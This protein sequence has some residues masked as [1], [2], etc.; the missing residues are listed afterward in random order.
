[1]F[2][3]S[4]FAFVILNFF[5]SSA[6]AV[7]LSDTERE[8]R[9][10]DF[11][12]ISERVLAQRS[13][14]DIIGNGAGLA[15]QNITYLFRHLDRYLILGLNQGEFLDSQQKEIVRK[16]LKLVLKNRFNDKA[17]IFLN[18]NIFEDFFHDVLDPEERIAKT[19]FSS[20]FPIFFNINQVYR[21]GLANEVSSLLG[22]LIHELG[23]QGGV[24]SHHYLDE[25]S[26]DLRM[27]FESFYS[28][29][30]VDYEGLEFSFS[31]YKEHGRSA[32]D[33]GVLSIGKKTFI[34]FSVNDSNYKCPNDGRLHSMN[35]QN[36]HFLNLEKKKDE[37]T[38]KISVWAEITCSTL[39]L[40]SVTSMRE[41]LSFEFRLKKMNENEEFNFHG[42]DVSREDFKRFEL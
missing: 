27:L 19:G 18:S 38:V 23:H 15:E 24:A 10:A 17:L 3:N 22:I 11:N 12:K 34:P 2:K 6:F 13:G 35:W 36:A 14:S 30:S 41:K 28:S 20:E 37:Y 26:A 33:R 21:T 8:S 40:N 31:H 7:Y 25:L 5:A 1:M 9:N 39:L 29:V 16:M 42:M 32:I 4:L